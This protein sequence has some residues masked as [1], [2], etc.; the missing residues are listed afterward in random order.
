MTCSEAREGILEADPSVLRGEGG[1]PLS[2]HLEQCEECRAL[3]RFVLAGEDR[4]G[5][6]LQEAPRRPSVEEILREAGGPP[7]TRLRAPLVLVPLLAAAGLAALLLMPE[8][9]M[10]EPV[11]TVP[12]AST[13]LNVDVPEGR[14]AA[15]L[16]TGDPNIT[17][18]WIF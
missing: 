10:P 7:P 17:V 2:L 6:F 5:T 8:A 16:T 1:D 15:V 4:L 18:L 9:P 13:G 12:P 11:H 14:S 3:A